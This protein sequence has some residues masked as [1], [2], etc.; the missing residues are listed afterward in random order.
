MIV[1]N[2]TQ[3]VRLRSRADQLNG[4]IQRVRAALPAR[5]K[6][7]TAEPWSTWVLTPEVG[8][9]CRRDL[10]PSAA[11]LGECRHQR[12][13]A[14]H[15]Q[16]IYDIMQAE[17]PDKPIIIGEA[18]WPSEGR[19][20]GSAPK[21]R[22][23]TKPI[24]CAPS[25]SCAME[26]GYDYYLFEGLRPA[27]EGRRR[28]RGRAPIGACST[29]PAIPNSPSPACCAA[30]PEWRGYA[31]L[32]AVLT[33]AAG[34]ADPGPHAAGAPDRLSGDG[35]ADRAGLDRPAGAD[36]RHR[37][38]IYRSHRHRRHDRACR[39]WCCWPAPSS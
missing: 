26:K 17:F 11:L 27:L 39:R 24:S 15:R 18:G 35:R 8:Q 6:V 5:I 37:A 28:R 30:F 32:A 33:P 19:T 10:R 25:S 20:R 9:A 31:L 22:S 13:A 1:G 3:T 21:P 38:G 7:T 34:P 23:P 4:Y 16:R 14:L 12:R 29:P 36:R 2:E